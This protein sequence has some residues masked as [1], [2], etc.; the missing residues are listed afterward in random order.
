MEKK[1]IK[2]PT[3]FSRSRRS[4]DFFQYAGM[5]SEMMAMLGIAV[6]AGYKLD[7]WLAWEVPVFLIFFPLVALAVFLWHLIKVTG[8]KD[9]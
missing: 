2:L 5:A 3:E 9:G 1:K 6:F 8:R 7:R 4:K